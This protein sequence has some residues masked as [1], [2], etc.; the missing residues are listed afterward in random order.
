MRDK[1]PG[2]MLGGWTVAQNRA[3]PRLMRLPLCIN[4]RP[5]PLVLLEQEVTYLVLDEADRM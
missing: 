2:H 4:S 3:L 5:P 1:A